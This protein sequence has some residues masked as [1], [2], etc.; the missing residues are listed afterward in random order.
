MAKEDK[1]RQTEIDALVKRLDNMSDKDWK[2]EHKKNVQVWIQN[3]LTK[4][5]PLKKRLTKRIVMGVM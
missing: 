4:T 1:E 5:V 3:S 2:A